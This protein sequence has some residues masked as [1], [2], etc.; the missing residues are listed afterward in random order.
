MK[1]LTISDIVVPEL[2]DRIDT[3]RFDGVDLVLSC[4]DLP[5]EYLASIRDQLDAPLYY[6]RGN[7]DIRYRNAPPI[8]CL[9]LHQRHITFGGLRIIGLEGSR[10]YNGGPIQYREYQMRRM[11]WSMMPRLWLGGGVDIVITHAPPRHIH[12]AEDR[13]HRGFE[14]FVKLIG[15]F[16]P[17]YFIH[18]HI[19]AHFADASQ[20]VTLVGDTRVINTFGCHLLEVKHG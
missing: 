13:C 16:K 3:R 7:H 1:I 5:P 12:D 4:G 20:R 2:S 18:G 9:N 6:V 11:I 14:S 15:R 17:R 8:G 10:W 19:H